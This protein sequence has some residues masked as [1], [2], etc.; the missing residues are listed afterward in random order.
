[1][2]LV[3]PFRHFEVVARHPHDMDAFTE[4]LIWYDGRLYEGTGIAGR[5]QLRLVDLETGAVLQSRKLSPDEF[6]EGVTILDDVIYQLTWRSNIAYAYDLDS[7]DEIG[8]FAFDGEGWGLTTDGTSLIM[9]N[10]SDQIVYR[11]PE[12]FEITR[13]I[14]V[15]DGDDPIFQLNELEY[16]DGVIWANVWHTNLIA[17]IDPETGSV[18]D[19]LD[20]S[21]LAAEMAASAAD[22]NVLNGIAWNPESETVLVT[23]KYWPVL[24][25]IQLTGSQSTS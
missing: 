8:T 10:G 23:G 7:F 5:S 24:F 6:G 9:S 11:D 19:W 2:T 18:L 22:G 13:T 20:L 12:T 14:S 15:R 16:I 21:S 17:R 3:A 25:E 1:M 4:G